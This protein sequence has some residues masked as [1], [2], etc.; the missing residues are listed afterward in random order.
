MFRKE[1]HGLVHRHFQDVVNVLSL[2]L[3]FQCVALEALAVATF[4]L[5][6]QIGHELHFY[7]NGTFTLTFFASSAFRVEREVSGRVSQLLGQRLV[8]IQLADFIVSLDVC[9]R[10]ASGGFADRVL[11][12]ELNVLDH[13]DVA[14]Q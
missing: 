2:E 7:R 12:D 8:G 13:L 11:V 10:I 3:D 6:D 1:F 14:S 5:Q 9:D 4:T